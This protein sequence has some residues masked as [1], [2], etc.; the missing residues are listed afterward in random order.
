MATPDVLT[1]ALIAT[2]HWSDYFSDDDFSD[3]DSSDEDEDGLISE[4]EEKIS[5]QV[6]LIK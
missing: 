6:V 5:N 1:D 3:D 4:I 2:R